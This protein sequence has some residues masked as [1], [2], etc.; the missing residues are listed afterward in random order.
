MLI[1]VLFALNY[2]E[3]NVTLL[4]LV[5]HFNCNPMKMLEYSGHFETLYS[6]GIL[7]VK[8]DYHKAGLPSTGESLMFNYMVVQAVVNNS[9]VPEI[10]R[11]EP[12]SIVDLLEQFYLLGL[13]R[14]EEEIPTQFLFRKA[15]ELIRSNLHYP[16]IKKIDDYHFCIE[17]TFL[18]IYLIWKT[19]SGQESVDIET[20][21]KGTFDNVPKRI[22]YMQRLIT[23]KMI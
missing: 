18:F 10:V 6:R 5:S 12:K 20:A 1:A 17:D 15:E 2:K 21:L 11:Q 8:S 23:K 3:Y 19:L 9:P 16:L 4:D 22:N 7:Q 14:S 13:Q